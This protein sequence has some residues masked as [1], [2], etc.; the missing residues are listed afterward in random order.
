MAQ[1][2]NQQVPLLFYRQA[3]R[4]LSCFAAAARLLKKVSFGLIL[5]AAPA[6]G[7]TPLL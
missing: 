4:G 2:R 7:V 5:N 6:A 3:A 1:Q